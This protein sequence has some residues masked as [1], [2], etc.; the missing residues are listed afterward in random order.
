M[1]TADS[2]QISL[3]ESAVVASPP[4]K[5]HVLVR[6]LAVLVVAVVALLCAGAVSASTNNVAHPTCLDVAAGSAQLPADGACYGG[7][8]FQ[9]YG[10]LVF[11]LLGAV[12]VGLALALSLV[13]LLTGRRGRLFLGALG[14]G[15]A[16]L[17]IGIL[18]THA[19]SSHLPRRAAAPASGSS[20]ALTLG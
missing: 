19:S 10:T 16:L 2:Y 13:L 4:R 9:Q 1:R 3:T 18:I 8:M 11:V 5:T 6:V 14:T 7:S 20:A 15:V 12:A 17:L